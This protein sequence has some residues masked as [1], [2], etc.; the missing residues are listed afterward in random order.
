MIRK[1]ENETLHYTLRSE[2]NKLSLRGGRAFVGEIKAH[3]V[4]HRSRLSG[5]TV[6][7]RSI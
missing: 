1:S 7:P 3:E 6:T 5:G 2:S 4:G